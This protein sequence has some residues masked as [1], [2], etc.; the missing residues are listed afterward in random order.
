MRKEE[1]V[2]T[3]L[4]FLELYTRAKVTA[5]FADMFHVQHA[6]AARVFL[7]PVVVAETAA[8]MHH[9][10]GRHKPQAFLEAG[11]P[12]MNRMEPAEINREAAAD[13]QFG[14][15]FPL[16]VIGFQEALVVVLVMATR[17]SK[18]REQVAHHREHGDSQATHRP[19]V[20]HFEERAVQ[21]DSRNAGTVFAGG[22]VKACDEAAGAVPEQHELYRVTFGTADKSNRG[23]EFGIVLRDVAEFA[24]GFALAVR[25][26]V[27]VQVDGIER[28]AR[29]IH[30]LRQVALEEVIVESVD[31][32]HG[33]LSRSRRLLN[34][35]GGDG[36]DGR[37]GGNIN[38]GGVHGLRRIMHE[39]RMVLRAITRI[40]SFYEKG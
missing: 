31:V 9:Q 8:A 40:K 24:D 2:Q 10:Y 12:R 29:G 34:G 21:H 4:D 3:V 18:A 27:L 1:V 36:R 11:M 38:G 32:K 33:R 39:S 6:V 15:V 30:L 17:N 23:I 14:I 19:R 7:A 22:S 25:T 16:A 26:A 13:L 35:I 20:V 37:C 28:I 5:V